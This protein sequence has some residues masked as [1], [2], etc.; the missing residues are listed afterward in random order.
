MDELPEGAIVSSMPLYPPDGRTVDPFS[1]GPIPFTSPSEAQAVAV[2]Q[3][4][5]AS[6]PAELKRH[7]I[8]AATPIYVVDPRDQHVRPAAI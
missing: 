1:S 6:P 3:A 4:F 2:A 8:G 7:N 5:R